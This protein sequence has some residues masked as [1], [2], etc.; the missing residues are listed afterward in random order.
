MAGPI[1]IMPCETHTHGGGMKHLWQITWSNA[2]PLGEAT[3]QG[4]SQF[5][6]YPS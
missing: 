5:K 2:V 6:T 1:I 3:G 4:I